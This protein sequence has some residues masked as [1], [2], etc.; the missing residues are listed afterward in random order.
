[1]NLCST[2]EVLQFWN[3]LE[4][5]LKNLIRAMKPDFWH[6]HYLY[7]SLLT[8]EPKLSKL[9][10]VVVVVVSGGHINPAVTLAMACFKRLKWQKVPVYWAGQTLGSLFASA[11][12]YGLYKGR[13]EPYTLLY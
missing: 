13:Y 4:V 2:T 6:Y 11:C 3:A 10:A 7:T 8:T 1:M 9:N 5:L 12:M